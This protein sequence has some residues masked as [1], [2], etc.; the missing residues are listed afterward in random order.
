M[1]FFLLLNVTAYVFQL[2]RAYR[3]SSISFLPCKEA[4]ADLFMHPCGGDRFYFAKHI[5]QRMRRP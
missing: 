2:R 4:T 5:R 1:M 3:E